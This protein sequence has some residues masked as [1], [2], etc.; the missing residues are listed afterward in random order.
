MEQFDRINTVKQYNDHTG[1]DTL[2]PLITVVKFRELPFV[3][4]F[5][6]HMRIF[7]PCS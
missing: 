5:R 3:C 2:H 7:V 1:V 4:N 6:R